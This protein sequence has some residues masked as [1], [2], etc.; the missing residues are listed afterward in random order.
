MRT[1]LRNAAFVFVGCLFGSV[2]VRLARGA[3]PTLSGAEE[4][5][6]ALVLAAVATLT[7]ILAHFVILVL[8]RRRS[9]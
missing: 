7:V 5:E 1:I 8:E 2:V 6:L 3:P 9:N 4:V